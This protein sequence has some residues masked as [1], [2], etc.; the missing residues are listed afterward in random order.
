MWPRSGLLRGHPLAPARHACWGDHGLRASATRL[1]AAHGVGL[2]WGEL[3]G[4][5][6]G[7]IDAALRLALTNGSTTV[8]P[9]ALPLSGGASR[10][11]VTFCFDKPGSV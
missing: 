11:S 10:A 1:E 8:D 5:E 4:S 2:V 6:P 7:V 9:D 3:C